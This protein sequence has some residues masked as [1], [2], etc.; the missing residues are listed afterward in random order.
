M[1]EEETQGTR[2]RHKSTGQ[3]HVGRSQRLAH[4]GLREVG[5]RMCPAGLTAVGWILDSK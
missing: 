2:A 5:G 4:R 1:I 3:E